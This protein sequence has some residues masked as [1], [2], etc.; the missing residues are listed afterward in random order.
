MVYFGVAFLLLW[1]VPLRKRIRLSL[2]SPFLPLVVLGLLDLMGVELFVIH[3][4]HGLALPNVWLWLTPGLIVR[5]PFEFTRRSARPAPKLKPEQYYVRGG[6]P[7]ADGSV[8]LYGGTLNGPT[9]FG[10]Y[11][12]EY[13]NETFKILAR[14]DPAGNFDA[15]FKPI[16]IPL[17]DVRAAFTET[18]GTVI[19]RSRDPATR[20]PVFS[21]MFADGSLK[22]IAKVVGYKENKPQIKTEPSGAVRLLPWLQFESEEPELIRLRLNGAIDEE[23]NAQAAKAIKAAKNLYLLTSAQLDHHG[24]AVVGLESGLLRLDEKG[25]LIPPGPVEIVPVGIGTAGIG[26]LAIAPDDAIF[27]T[28][29]LLRRFDKNLRED[30]SFNDQL[31]PQLDNRARFH[32]LGFRDDGVVIVSLVDKETGS[33]ILF[34]NRQGRVIREVPRS[35][36]K[37]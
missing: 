22:A 15:S 29:R 17:T 1:K 26:A 34:L 3:Q 10:P 12:E 20:Y 27:T 23:F 30:I 31:P 21:Q 14:L 8:I 11:D 33:R 35:Y 18:G 36:L 37:Q 25:M 16:I 32:V 4:A 13:D 2:I 9:E 6:M 5:A 19:V 28:G 7:R 24:R